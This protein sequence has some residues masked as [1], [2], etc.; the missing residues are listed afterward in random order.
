MLQGSA[1]SLNER[2]TLW[3][4]IHP[5]FRLE[6]TVST[7]VTPK[8]LLPN[9]EMAREKNILSEKKFQVNDTRT[10]AKTLNAEIS[11]W[12]RDCE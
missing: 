12:K 5:T 4:L 8:P 11:P 3:K 10:S 7:T 6:V 9:Q 2:H 1:I